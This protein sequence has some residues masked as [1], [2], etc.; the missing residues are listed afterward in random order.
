MQ[1]SAK[2]FELSKF[3]KKATELYR[4]GKEYALTLD[5]AESLDGSSID[6]RHSFVI[7]NNRKPLDSSDTDMFSNATKTRQPVVCKILYQKYLEDCS[8]VY[9]T[10]VPMRD[11]I[12]RTREENELTF[13]VCNRIG[14]DYIRSNNISD[15][16]IITDNLDDIYD[17]TSTAVDEI[18]DESIDDEA[19]DESDEVVIE[20]IDDAKSDK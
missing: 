4:L 20:I 16:Y 11:F 8:I 10:F 9:F 12:N 13:S 7:L 3:T 1:D 19:E 18:S 6:Y 5:P 2:T 14:T 15:T 17:I